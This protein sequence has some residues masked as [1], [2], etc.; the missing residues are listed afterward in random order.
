M[1]VGADEG[2]T[3]SLYLHVFGRFKMDAVFLGPD[4]HVRTNLI[5]FLW[6]SLHVPLHTA[7]SLQIVGNCYHLELSRI[8]CSLTLHKKRIKTT[9]GIPSRRRY[10][11]QEKF[12]PKRKF[13]AP[14]ECK[15]L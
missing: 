7:P 2:E 3:T 12:S 11:R 5:G 9:S 6:R 13:V 14:G 4:H 8:G 1:E 10:Q 15:F